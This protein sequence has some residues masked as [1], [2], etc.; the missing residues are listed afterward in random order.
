VIRRSLRRLLLAAFWVPFAIASEAALAPH[1]PPIPI[2]V[3]DVILH[4]FAFSYLT[5]ALGLAHYSSVGGKPRRWRAPVA[6]M[7]L[8]GVAIEAIQ[9]FIPERSAEVT[10]LVVDAF[11][12][13]I[14]VAIWLRALEPLVRRFDALPTKGGSG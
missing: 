1:G 4:L 9:Y 8:Y 13:A 5:A 10:D 14:G 2:E 7:A 11:G 3:S 6:W 12:I